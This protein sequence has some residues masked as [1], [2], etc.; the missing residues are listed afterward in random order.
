MSKATPSS[1]TSTPAGPIQTY[2]WRWIMLGIFVLN[3]IINNLAWITFAPVANVMRCYYGITND[4]VNTLS[5]V[6]SIL[7]LLLV[8]PGSWMLVQFGV[9][10]VLVVSSA[11]TAVGVALRVGG[12]GSGYFSLLIG[13]QIVSSFNGVMA[14][15]ITLFSETWFPSTERATATAFA[16]SVAPQVRGRV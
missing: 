13:G 11:A 16:A 15:S 1:S 9:R 7:M 14:G 5:L 10:F 4:V 8:L 3:Q 6:S 2:W 12:A